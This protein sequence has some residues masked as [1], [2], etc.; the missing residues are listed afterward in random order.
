[1]MNMQQLPQQFYN[2]I[3]YQKEEEEEE[4]DEKEEKPI[5]IKKGDEQFI[6]KKCSL[7]EHNDVDAIFYCQECRIYICNKCEKIH[8]GLLKNHHFYKIDTNINEIFTGLC[9]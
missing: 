5:N 6:K 7:N 9:T 1:M 2:P 4:E 3:L 8:S